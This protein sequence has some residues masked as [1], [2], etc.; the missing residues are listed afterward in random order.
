MGD[1]ISFGMLG[2]GSFGTLGGGSFG[3]LDGGSFG[4]LDGE[5]FFF[6]CSASKKQEFLSFLHQSSGY[7]RTGA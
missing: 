1:R 2:G 3:T 6:G 5:N 7:G 4:T